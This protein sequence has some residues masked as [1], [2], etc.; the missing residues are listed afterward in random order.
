VSKKQNLDGLDKLAI[1]IIDCHKC[2]R[3]VRWREKVSVEKR[4]SY[5]TENY[6]GKPI[7]GFGDKQARIIV[8][9]LAPGA[10]GAN[11]TGRVFTGD[12]SGDWLYRAMHK[13]GL[14]SQPESVSL[15]D[16]LTL[17]NAWV[18]SAVRCAPPANK[19]TPGERKKCSSFLTRELEM[20]T[21]AK[22]IICLGSFSFQAVCDEL[23]IRPRPKFGHGVVVNHD[24]YKI[25]CSYHPSQQNTFTGKLTEKMFNN[26]FKT[27]LKLAR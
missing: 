9:G 20:L 14:A 26:I 10:H 11:R 17:Q 18:T 24:I 16:G 21:N 19:P 22:V 25:V 27:A 12:R 2:P 13:A 15:N 8:L 3:L 23:K 6:W 1:E 4:A 5:V 7:V